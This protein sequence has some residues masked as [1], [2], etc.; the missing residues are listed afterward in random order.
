MESQVSTSRRKYKG[1]SRNGAGP[2]VIGGE[3]VEAGSD[4]GKS[5]LM[6]FLSGTCPKFSKQMH[7]LYTT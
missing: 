6:S 5:Q 3:Q 2:S 1:T 4:S 7:C